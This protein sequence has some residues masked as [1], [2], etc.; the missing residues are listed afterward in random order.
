[1]RTISP[2][3]GSD[4]GVIKFSLIH[5]AGCSLAG[6]VTL[7]DN[8]LCGLQL[9]LCP[10]FPRWDHPLLEE[11]AALGAKALLPPPTTPAVP[12]KPPPPYRMIRFGCRKL[13]L[14]AVH[15]ASWHR[16]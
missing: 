7:E 11:A 3:L 1:M 4:L 6:T 13:Y 5:G 8:C 14:A 16:V 12:Q 9:V 15:I 10:V 2:S